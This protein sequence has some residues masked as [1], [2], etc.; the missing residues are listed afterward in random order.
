MSQLAIADLHATIRS[1]PAG[2]AAQRNAEL[3]CRLPGATLVHVLGL[4]FTDVGDDTH[5]WCGEPVTA[6]VI[7]D[8]LTKALGFSAELT[9]MNPHGR[10]LLELGEMCA[11]R[12]HFWAYRWLTVGILMCG[13]GLSVEL[14][15]ARDSR[16]LL[17]WSDIDPHAEPRAF[18]ATAVLK[19]WI[20]FTAHAS[21]CSFKAPERLAMSDC[22]AQLGMIL[23]GTLSVR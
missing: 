17:G 10:S 9:Y 11:E 8:A 16:F 6:G 13:Y 20:A 3:C 21:D 15:F 14:A 1:L 5:S 19:D 18:I 4:P 22:S 23:P 12:K 7:R 2:T